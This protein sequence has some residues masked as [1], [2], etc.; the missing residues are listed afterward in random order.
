MTLRTSQRLLLAT[1]ESTSG[2]DPTPTGA[3]N[4]ILVRNLEISPFQSDAVERELIRG[5]MGNYEVLHA[6]QRVE[7]T[8][9][10]EMVGSG[11]A[12]TSGGM[13]SALK[14]FAVAA[15]ESQYSSLLRILKLWRHYCCCCKLPDSP[16]IVNN[17]N[18]K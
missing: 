17:D 2:T 7:V 13:E 5:Y 15:L 11:A 16:G 10:V 4:A 6:N 8:F 9:E 1:I 14:T 12:G 3:A 18:S